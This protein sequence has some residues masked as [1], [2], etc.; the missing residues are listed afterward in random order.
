MLK[1]PLQNLPLPNL[2]LSVAQQ[3][4]A[5]MPIQGPVVPLEQRILDLLQP[6][7]DDCFTA[8]DETTAARDRTVLV[9][10][11]TASI[12]RFSRAHSL[13]PRDNT[14]KLKEN[15][16]LLIRHNQPSYGKRIGA[17]DIS[18]ASRNWQATKTTGG[19]ACIG[20]FVCGVATTYTVVRVTVNANEDVIDCLKEETDSLL[21]RF[22]PDT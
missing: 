1:L 22:F 10:C 4:Q 11:G 8:E 18:M 16:A 7:R 21:Q 3:A 14:D 20:I 17:H 2:G 6:Y 5:P 12:S 13:A 15:I 9:L 19:Q